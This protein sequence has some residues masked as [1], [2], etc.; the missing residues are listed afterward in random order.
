MKS[1]FGK[2]RGGKN[3]NRIPPIDRIAASIA[4]K[5]EKIEKMARIGCFEQENARKIRTKKRER[6]AE[7]V[8]RFR[9]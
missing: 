1:T 8:H 7:G 3:L 5:P 2:G 9:D 4:H 6:E